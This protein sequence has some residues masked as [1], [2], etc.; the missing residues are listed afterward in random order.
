[1]WTHIVLP[2]QLHGVQG[3]ELP[4]VGDEGL[5][6]IKITFFSL[7]ALELEGWRIISPLS[8]SMRLISAGKEGCFPSP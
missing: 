7:N 5:G 1:M 4:K 2:L 3:T 8:H 6:D